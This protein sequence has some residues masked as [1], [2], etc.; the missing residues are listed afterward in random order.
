MNLRIEIFLRKATLGVV[1]LSLSAC[2][3]YQTKVDSSRTLLEEGRYKEA[4]EKLS[5]LAAEK[6]GD[7][8][9][10]LLDYGTALSVAGQYEKS[11]QILLQA[12]QLIEELDYLSVSQFASSLALSEEM[13]QYQGDTFEKIF[14]HALL[15]FNFLSLGQKDSAL[16]EARRINE[17]LQKYRNDQ[18]VK[19]YNKVEFGS[20]LAGHIWEASG[21]FDS[22]YISFETTYKMNPSYPGIEADLIR[23]SKKSRRFDAY[24]K[25]K[26]KFATVLED[27]LWY[28]PQAANLL[29]IFQQGWGPRKYPDPLDHRFPYLRPVQSQIQS[30]EVQLN[31][32]PLGRTQLSYSITEA[33]IQTLAEDRAAIVAKRVAAYATKEVLSDQIRQKDEALGALAQIFLHLSDRADVRQWST[34]PSAIQ[35]FRL[36]MKPQEGI[37]T[38]HGVDRWGQLQPIIKDFG[39]QNFQARKTHFFIWRGF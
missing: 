11:N 14:V 27:P 4:I 36:S 31:Q 9:V 15:A 30:C 6:S 26:K 21:E 5:V 2:A 37:L 34:L 18:N 22:A 29:V 13:K 8:L 20:Y 32:K 1:S 39:T 35:L 33:S 23:T 25:W 28:D 17:K 10:Y 24:Q 12:A 3:T 38:L 19:D 7:Q 16:V